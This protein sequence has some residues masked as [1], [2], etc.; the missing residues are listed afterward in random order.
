MYF[1]IWALT[2][3]NWTFQVF[4]VVSMWSFLQHYFR[5]VCVCLVVRPR[6][7]WLTARGTGEAGHAVLEVRADGR[8][9]GKRG[10]GERIITERTRA[11]TRASKRASRRACSDRSDTRLTSRLCVDTHC[12]LSRFNRE[13]VLRGTLT[14]SCTPP[15]LMTKEREPTCSNTLDVLWSQECVWS[16]EAT[17]KKCYDSDSG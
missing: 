12:L 2:L 17:W 8:G 14:A 7:E 5:C 10:C 4:P 15:W 11:E 1:N 13:V 3:T 9:R 16:K 6:I